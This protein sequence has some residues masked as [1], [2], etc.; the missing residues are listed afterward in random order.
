[1]VVEP[2]TRLPSRLVQSDWDRGWRA[3]VDAFGPRGKHIPHRRAVGHG[4]EDGEVTL[5]PADPPSAV[6]TP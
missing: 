4:H 6:R 3:E 5:G 2:G 1:V